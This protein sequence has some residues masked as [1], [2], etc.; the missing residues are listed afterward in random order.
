VPVAADGK[1]LL[2]NSG[3]NIDLVADLAGSYTSQ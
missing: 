2:Y 3:G 1:V